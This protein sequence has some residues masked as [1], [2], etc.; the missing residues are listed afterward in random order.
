VLYDRPT[1]QQWCARSELVVVAEFTAP[2]RVWV[3]PDGSDRQEHY[4]V[5]VLE[6]LKG[7]APGDVIEYF[8]HVEGGAGYQPGDRAVVFLERT[9]SRPELLSLAPRFAWYSLQDAG[10]EW[11]LAAERP[12][13]V[14]GLVADWLG[15]LAAPALEG[16]PRTRALLARELRS[17]DA[18]VRADALADLVR[19]REAPGFFAS[20]RD[21]APF[22]QRARERAAPAADRIALALLLRGQPG[23]D[24]AAALRALT[25]EPLAPADRVTLIRVAGGVPDEALSRWLEGELRAPD[26]V[27]RAEAAT[28]LGHPFHAPRTPALARLLASEDPTVAG[29]AVRGLQGI[30]TPEARAALAAAAREPALASSAL[31]AAALRRLEAA[32]AAVPPETSSPAGGM[33]P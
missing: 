29:A 10:Q 6:T 9:A 27:R 1:L 31:A 32:S 24:D 23:F 19:L 4:A 18:R 11:R 2:L 21:V 30:G 14:P 17:S 3:A 5:R 33:L 12:A 20:A 8:P 26:P 7:E 25:R 15:A 13:E 28:A 22:A 16:T